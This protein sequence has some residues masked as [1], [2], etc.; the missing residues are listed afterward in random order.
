MITT[1]LLFALAFGF[2]LMGPGART[3]A[4]R[5]TN[6][7]AAARCNPD[8]DD[9]ATL[10]ARAASS[11]GDPTAPFDRFPAVGVAGLPGRLV[12]GE[13]SRSELPLDCAPSSGDPGRS[14]RCGR[15]STAS[16]AAGRACRVSRPL[17]LGT[18]S[19]DPHW[20]QRQTPPRNPSSSSRIV[21]Q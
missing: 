18:C 9:A 3:A 8:D 12:I 4:L 1:R 5:S 19:S 11:N 16:G 13:R 7:D 14:G 17:A 2:N 15:V 20:A 21:E 10:A 6:G